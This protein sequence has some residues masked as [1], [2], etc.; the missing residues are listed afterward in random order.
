MGSDSPGK[1]ELPPPSLALARLL[2]D[3]PAHSLAI[4]EYQHIAHAITRGHQTV[5]AIGFVL[6]ASSPGRHRR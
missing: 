3:L 6:D 2:R 1:Q 5:I 4:G